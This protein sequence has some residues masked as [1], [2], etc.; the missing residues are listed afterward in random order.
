M[1]S[2]ANEVT[3]GPSLYIILGTMEGSE[4]LA[5]LQSKLNLIEGG[6]G[7]SAKYQALMQLTALGIT[8]AIAVVA[9]LLTGLLINVEFLCSGLK[10]HELFEDFEF[11]DGAG[12]EPEITDMTRTAEENEN[13]TTSSQQAAL[14]LVAN[15]QSIYG[16]EE[17]GSE[18]SNQS[19]GR[20]VSFLHLINITYIFFIK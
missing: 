2:L 18:S 9:G 16:Q 4:E 6:L 17:I 13:R 8:L 15:S 11:F 10:D 20:A 5:V 19:F 14:A 3:Y 7:W 12:E 1:C